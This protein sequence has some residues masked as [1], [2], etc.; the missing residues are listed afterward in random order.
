VSK[1]TKKPTECGGV[2]LNLV[3]ANAG[4]N[5]GKHDVLKIKRLNLLR[6][7]SVITEAERHEEKKSSKGLIKGG[8]RRCERGENHASEK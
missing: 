8:V 1:P 4:S 7:S 6:A 3:A 5:S 2:L